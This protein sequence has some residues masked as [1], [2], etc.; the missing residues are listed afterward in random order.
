MPFEGELQQS[1]W[2]E[3]LRPISRAFQGEEN[4]IGLDDLWGRDDDPNEIDA[5][6]S[7]W[8]TGVERAAQETKVN[9]KFVDQQVKAQG[10]TFSLPPA[11]TRG[12]AIADRRAVARGVDPGP[13]TTGVG[14][15]L[16]LAKSQLG[17]NYVWAASN[18]GTAFDCSGFTQWLYKR[19]MGVNL[20]H[21]AATQ[22]QQLQK[23]NRD[24]LQA[25]DLL[26]FD[27]NGGGIDHVEVYMGGDKMIGTGNTTDDLDIDSVPWDGF[28]GGGRAP[29][30][31]AAA[32]AAGGAGVTDPVKPTK[33]VKKVPVENHPELAP[34]LLADGAPAFSSVLAE[35]FMPD[36]QKQVTYKDGVEA[37][38]FKGSN[39]RVERQL[40]AGFMDAGRP[41][42]AQLVGTKDFT[43]WINAESGWNVG[44]VS[45]YYAGHG[46]NYGLFQFWQGHEW[47]KDY[48]NG[49]QWGASPYEQAQLVAKYFNLSTNDVAT[50]ADQIR[51]GNYHGWG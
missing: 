26:F 36:W 3:F 45:Q 20:A 15:M 38:A 21:H 4:H 2:E 10:A 42:L 11:A 12:D 8:A 48:L 47:T 7:E 29:G 18:P 27:W 31:A 1:P 24:E 37:P 43:T 44:S 6:R 49:G 19:S 30:A 51:S 34:M 5:W 41:D 13:G 35:I 9:E 25:G 32:P 16:D 28:V 33:V 17:V 39:A 23:V 40:Y 46:R 22:Y 14:N 50:Y